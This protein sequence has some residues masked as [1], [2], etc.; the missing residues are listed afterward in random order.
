MQINSMK[1]NQWLKNLWK[2]HNLISEKKIKLNNSF[3]SC[4]CTKFLGSSLI[5]KKWKD[6]ESS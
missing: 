6:T 2:K 1:Q 3:K 4:N 5:K